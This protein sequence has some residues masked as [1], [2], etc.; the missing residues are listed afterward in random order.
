MLSSEQTLLAVGL[1]QYKENAYTGCTILNATQQQ[2]CTTVQKIK[3]EAG[4]PLVTH[5]P[6][7]PLETQVKITIAA[8]PL[9]T[10]ICAEAV[11]VRTCRIVKFRKC[12]NS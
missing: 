11:H 3:S 9:S 6:N 4:P 12:A 5:S 1:C 7:L 2:S 10:P 8:R